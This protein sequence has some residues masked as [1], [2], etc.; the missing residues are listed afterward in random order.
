MGGF[1]RNIESGGKKKKEGIY[2]PIT[3]NQR[4]LELF[5]VKLCVAGATPV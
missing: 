4:H 2:S 1:I 5:R 3:Q